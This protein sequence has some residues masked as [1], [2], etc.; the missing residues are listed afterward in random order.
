MAS[1]D[2]KDR[3]CRARPTDRSLV[4][5]DRSAGGVRDQ[6]GPASTPRGQF[7]NRCGSCRACHET[8]EQPLKG[9]RVAGRQQGLNAIGPLRQEGAPG[10]HLRDTVMIS[11]PIEEVFEFLADLENV[12]T[13][14]YAIVETHRSPKGPSAWARS[15]SKPLGPEP[16]QRALR[17]H[18]L[19]PASAAG[20]TRP[21]RAVPLTP[22][23][24]LGRRS[25]GNPHHER[26]RARTPRPWPPARASRRATCPGRR[27]RQPPE[28][29][30]TA[31]A[32]GPRGRAF[33]PAAR[34]CF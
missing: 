2:R 7:R 16:Q 19:Q 5:E 18:R 6:T 30:G 17:G 4:A 28:A 1:R 15:T 10:G 13:W 9:R 29:Q 31:G 26:G 24:C 11:R 3:P 22:R 25:R 34:S 33:T 27:G 23:L 20:D 21:T 14:N 32:I 12:S 8:G